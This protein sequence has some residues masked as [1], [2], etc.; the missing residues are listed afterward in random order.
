MCLYVEYFYE[1]NL[2]YKI[3]ISYQM[4]QLSNFVTV[5]FKL[6]FQLIILS[7]KRW[8]TVS[9][10]GSEAQQFVERNKYTY[11]QWADEISLEDL[12]KAHQ[13]ILQFSV[14]RK[15]QKATL[16]LALKGLVHK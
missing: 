14:E 12:T 11:L 15:Q 4:C 1:N 7:H 9:V 5:Y 3:A 16:Q 6:I 10:V 13:E 2:S 8:T